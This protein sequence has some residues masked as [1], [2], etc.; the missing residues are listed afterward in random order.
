MCRHKNICLDR[1]NA[2]GIATAKLP[3]L[4]H[5]TLGT[6]AVLT[7]NHVVEVG[8]YDKGGFVVLWC[9]RHALSHFDVW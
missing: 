2:A 7:V 8:G 3:I 9:T 4:E 6:S 5:V 1:A